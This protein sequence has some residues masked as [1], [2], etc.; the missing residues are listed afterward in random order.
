MIKD[1]NNECSTHIT[2]IINNFMYY[3][4]RDRNGFLIEVN[5]EILAKAIKFWQRMCAAS[6]GSQGGLSD[7]LSTHP[8]DEKRIKNLQ[9]HLPEALEYYK[10][11]K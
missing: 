8:S 9:E 7:F 4:K 10:K 5:D 6:G 3:E 2:K 11:S 1:N